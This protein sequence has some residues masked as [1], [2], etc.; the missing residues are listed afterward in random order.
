MSDGLSSTLGSLGMILS[1]LFSMAWE[2][3]HHER[4]VFPSAVLQRNR[5][6]CLPLPLDRQPAQVAAAPLFKEKLG[7]LLL[8]QPPSLFVDE[9]VCHRSAPA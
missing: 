2:A 8:R 9:A 6:L 7:A 3:D 4:L 1:R 5:V